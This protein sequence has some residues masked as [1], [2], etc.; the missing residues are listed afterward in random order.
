MASIVK[1]INNQLSKPLTYCAY[2]YFVKQ[3]KDLLSSYLEK[4]NLDK[5]TDL[6][7]NIIHKA[8]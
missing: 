3:N 8:L 7:L 6:D 4:K 1:I 2:V 5:Q